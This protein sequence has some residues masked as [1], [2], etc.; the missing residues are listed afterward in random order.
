MRAERVAWFLL[1][2]A[3]VFGLLAATLSM[4]VLA[5]WT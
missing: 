1:G 2:L 4:L 3:V 5:G